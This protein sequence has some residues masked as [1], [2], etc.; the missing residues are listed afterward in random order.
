[1]A[2]E[3]KSTPIYKVS[4]KSE[5]NPL[6]GTRDEFKAQ[7]FDSVN[8]IIDA[9]L[10]TT[11]FFN[12]YINEEIIPYPFLIIPGTKSKIQL[13]TTGFTYEGETKDYN[14]WNQYLNDYY[15]E[16]Y[17]ISLIQNQV[18]KKDSTNI[19]IQEIFK[20]K[21]QNLERLNEIKDR[22]NL[23]DAEY[24]YAKYRVAYLL[25]TTIYSELVRV[26]P[27]NNIGYEFLNNLPLNDVEAANQSIDY[28]RALEVFVLYKLRLENKWYDFESIDFNSDTFATLYY[29]KILYLIKNEKVRNILITRKVCQS[30]FNGTTSSESLYN[31]Y[32]NECTDKNLKIIAQ[33]YYNE[34]LS[35]KKT[36]KP[37][38]NIDSL[39]ISL[40]EKLKEKKGKVLYLDLWAS[41]CG[42]CIQGIPFTKKLIDKFYGQPFEVVYVNVNDNFGSFETTAKKLNLEGTLIY[43][44][45]AESKEIKKFVKAE[46]IPHYLLIDKNGEIIELNAPDPR[47][48]T[49]ITQIEQLLNQ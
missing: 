14:Q 30:L 47:S 12:L 29:Q 34:F 20:E 3:I 21:E 15:L 7:I 38:M 35:I 36:V 11:Q 41:W 43:L 44:N 23:S 2:G 26:Y 13:D 39:R 46:G 4:I 48:K 10:G 8:F 19:V 5:E 28:N 9:K 6:T 18:E 25:Y 32:L 16:K 1:M 37:K 40:F 31:R 33:G 24:Q 42:P 22:F 49:L 45:D 27:V 17:N